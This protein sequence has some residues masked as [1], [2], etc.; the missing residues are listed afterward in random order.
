MDEMNGTI[1]IQNGYRNSRA[2]LYGVFKNSHKF[3]KH[4]NIIVIKS[5]S[6]T[7]GMK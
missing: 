3:S 5:M 1:P 2:I 6:Y 7:T 4:M